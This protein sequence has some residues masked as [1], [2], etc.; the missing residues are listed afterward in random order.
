MF[1]LLFSPGSF[2]RVAG[3]GVGGG[4][5]LIVLSANTIA[6]DAADNSVVGALSVTNP[7]GTYV[8]TIESGDDPDNKFAISGSNLIIDELLD[9]E[10]ATSHSVTIT[11][12]P[13]VG[14]TIERTFTITV[15]DVSD[16]PVEDIGAIVITWDG[17]GS[18]DTPG[19]A[20]DLPLGNGSP[21]DVEEGDNLVF[22]Y[23]TNGGSSWTP[24]ITITITA[25]H[26][27]GDPLS[28]AGADPLADGEWDFD[29]RL[30]R[31]G[32]VSPRATEDVTVETVAPVLTSATSEAAGEAGGV[33]GVTT[34]EGNGT[35]WVV[36][37]TSATTP[38]A[39]QIVD[40]ED[41]LGAAAAF[42][43]DETVVGT[44]AQE[45]TADGLDAD[46][47]YYG[48]FVHLDQFSNVSNT[49]STAQFTTEE[50]IVAVP[51]NFDGTNDYLTRAGLAAGADG[52]KGI[53]SFW[54][55]I[56][57]GDGAAQN[58]LTLAASGSTKFALVRSSANRWAFTIRNAAG[59]DLITGTPFQT[60]TT[61]VAGVGWHHFI[62]SWDL[63][64]GVASL[65]LYIDKVDA[66][67]GTPTVTAGDIDYVT[68]QAAI[69]AAFAGTS[70]ISMDL[71]EFYFNIAERIDLSVAGNLL[72]W[73]NA[74][75]KPANIG[76]DGSAPTGTQPV[77]YLANPL[78]T[79]QD[80]LGTGGN[81]TENGALSAS[82]T[83]PSD[84]VPDAFEVGDWS[85][86][87]GDTEIEV[88]ISSLPYDGGDTITDVEYR[89]DGGAWTTSGGTTDFTITS[90]SNGVEY[91]VELRA[92]NS[93]GEG[94]ASDLKSETPVAE[95]RQFMALGSYVN[96]TGSRQY[97][98]PGAYLVDS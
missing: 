76:A 30:E 21:T 45:I 23:T 34:D 75:D 94:A 57:A 50:T 73:N 92:V 98:I 63:D 96:A 97:L 72:K 83:G 52:R 85:L 1:G 53:L 66:R 31:S 64:V 90:L 39:Q 82:S 13:D 87:A 77:I 26:I 32:H 40:G 93:L 46:T 70:K 2:W 68:N 55:Q 19:F 9:Y 36:V 4:T 56:N 27:S 14:A 15:T 62:A 86:A 51:V 33:L 25:G 88:T 61:M 3:G 11:A 79:W 81:F 37:T 24:Y 74:A 44:G 95:A 58:V 38:T 10:T 35:L 6:E 65:Q 16:D 69:G 89:V 42:A 84:G 20:V 22:R 91:D 17:V 7:E 54:Y 5:P 18:D 8:F 41:H 59:T 12:N 71:A 29:A 78:A 28:F 48:H 43:G 60:G 47:N 80:N 67:S 49:I